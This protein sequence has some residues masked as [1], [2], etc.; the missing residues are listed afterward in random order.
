MF[1]R[2]NRPNGIR[3]LRPGITAEPPVSIPSAGDVL[4]GAGRDQVRALIQRAN[5]AP[6]REK[7]DADGTL[8]EPYKVAAPLPRNKSWICTSCHQEVDGT[9]NHGW[10]RN[11][12]TGQPEPCRTCSGPVIRARNS[13]RAEKL[14]RTGVGK[15]VFS[16]QYNLPIEGEDLCFEDFPGDQTALARVKQF[17]AGGM[18]EL[19][20]YG[21][22]GR[23]KT[24]LGISAVHELVKAGKQVLFMTLPHYIHWLRQDNLTQD[25]ATKIQMKE[26][27]AKVETLVLD[28]LGLES[29]T[30]ANVRDIQE[31]LEFRHS[32]GLHTLLISNM[33][34]EGLEQYWYQPD[35]ARTG[36]QP[37]ARIA[38]RIGKV[39][40]KGWYM[41]CQIGGEDLR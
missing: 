38:S 11:A 3:P 30:L 31:L 12:Q 23:G 28:E 17:V 27:G 14:I 36:F 40:G 33:S 4:T 10:F 18:A 32:A 16:D 15:Y 29:P 24:G 21:D 6:A 41:K 25:P 1:N 20:L 22:T 9:E 34:P 2:Y 19:F 35:L 13:R 37:S 39:N 5:S 8:L 7:V 26:I